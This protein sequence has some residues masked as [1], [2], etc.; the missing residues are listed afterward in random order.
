MRNDLNA[1][2]IFVTAKERAGI[3]RAVLSNAFAKNEFNKTL[4]AKF[5]EVVTQQE[6]LLNLF[7]TVASKSFNTL[8]AQTSNDVSFNEV[9]KMRKIAQQK[10]KHNACV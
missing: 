7:K 1:L 6:I 4:Y 8:Y 10:E 2:A 3:E 5:I 9:D